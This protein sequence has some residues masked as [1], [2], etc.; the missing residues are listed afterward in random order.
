MRQTGTWI[1]HD[2]RGRLS[3]EAA[4]P[5]GAA[6]TWKHMQ[7]GLLDCSETGL[8]GRWLSVLEQS[9]QGRNV[10]KPEAT[11]PANARRRPRLLTCA[12]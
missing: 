1:L 10:R 6:W 2:V 11:S 8:W 12:V 4:S 7:P 5:G 9:Q 3:E